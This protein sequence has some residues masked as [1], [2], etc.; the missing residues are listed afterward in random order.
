[1]PSIV[2][3]C[4]H[5][6]SAMVCDRLLMR[7]GVAYRC[8]DAAAPAL[9]GGSR[10]SPSMMEA[11]VPPCRRLCFEEEDAGTPVSAVSSGYLSDCPC[12][13][14]TASPKR[15][16][17]LRRL[18]RPT[19]V[20]DRTLTCGHPILRPHHSPLQTCSE[21]V[22]EESYPTPDT[23]FGRPI[24][25]PYEQERPSKADRVGTRAE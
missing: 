20:R 12:P 14:S 10:W 5:H 21:S 24:R 1:M 3:R 25:V 6:P 17:S 19:T 18:I 16:P 9:V 2:P 8:N 11:N 13:N 22:R 23:T 4:R 15:S 7:M